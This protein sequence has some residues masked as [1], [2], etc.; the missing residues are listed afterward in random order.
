MPEKQVVL[1]FV[2]APITGQV[3]TRLA[4]D[5][6]EEAALD[7]YKLFTSDILATVE[8]AGYALR[9]FFSPPEG[10]TILADWLPSRYHLMPQE[11]KDLG[12]KMENAFARIFAEGFSSA[13][14]IGSDIPDLP[15]AIIHEAFFSLESNDAVIGPAA[16]GGY[17]LIGFKKKTFLPDV[18]HGM[19]WSTRGV[20]SK[21]LPVLE[22]ALHCFHLAPRWNDID[23]LDD[24]RAFFHRNKAVD[25]IQSGTMKYL[26][27]TRLL[28]K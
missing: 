22:R 20:L 11:G 8:E 15:A 7:L 23:T 17:Y 28:E 25:V 13:V 10:K 5:I 12:A 4:G 21:T 14:L 6:G 26:R 2:K 3:K 9:I 19:P 18:F 16:D 27:T 1:L 24:L